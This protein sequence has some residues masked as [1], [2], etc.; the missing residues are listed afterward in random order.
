MGKDK[1]EADFYA[2]DLG[3]GMI[4]FRGKGWRNRSL[5]VMN[6]ELQTVYPL[7]NPYGVLTG[8]SHNDIYWESVDKLEH[9]GDA[10]NLVARY[11]FGLGAYRDGVAR[12]D[13]ML[14]PDG[15][16]FADESGFGM[17]DNDE[18]NVSA[19]IDKECRV[20]VKF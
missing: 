12:F 19:Y 11:S 16:H 17:E 5:Y 1:K 7:V 6:T 10:M 14:Y 13:W 18:V 20:L 3:C 15:Q 2:S 9:N 4:L 8:F